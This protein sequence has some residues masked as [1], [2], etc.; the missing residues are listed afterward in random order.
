MLFMFDDKK[1]LGAESDHVGDE[2]DSHAGDGTNEALNSATESNRACFG[3]MTTAMV[4]YILFT[5]DLIGV[6]YRAPYLFRVCSDPR[7]HK[8]LNAADG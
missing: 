5:A 7:C 1:A 6:W 4:P 2:R 3:G 8:I